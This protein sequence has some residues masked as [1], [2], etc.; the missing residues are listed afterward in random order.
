MLGKYPEGSVMRNTCTATLYEKF[1]Y[2]TRNIIR[3]EKFQDV[4]PQARLAPDKQSLS[5][6]N[7][8]QAKQVSYFGAGVGG[9]IIGFGASLV[10]ITDDLYKSLEDA[11]SEGTNEKVHRWKESAHD[12]RL[13]RN[14]PKID[15]GTRWSTKDVIGKNIDENKYDLSIVVPALNEQGNSFCE[16]VKTTKEYHDIKRSILPEIWEAE[17][18]QNPAELKGILFPESSLKRF[19]LEKFRSD[20]AFAKQK[21]LEGK[22]HYEETKLGYWDIADEG[23]DYLCALIGNVKGGKIYVTDVLYTIENVNYTVP[24]SQALIEKERPEYVR[25]ETNGQGAIYIKWMT[26]KVPDTVTLLPVFNTQNKHTRIVMSQA[27]VTRNMYF[28]QRD[29]I[30]PGSDYDQFM[31]NLTSYMKDGSSKHEDGPDAVSGLAV[32]FQDHLNHLFDE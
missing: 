30:E 16:D 13:E 24:A 12:S 10:A 22:E 17:Y 4:F 28:V 14:C 7:L 11:L 26:D 3:S 20:E 31:R 23:D 6:W 29:E 27:F 1:S 25:M 2:D 5:G 18:M 19:S 21:A 32:F 15:I 8:T 9:T